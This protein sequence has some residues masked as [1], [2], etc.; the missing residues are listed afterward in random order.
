MHFIND[1]VLC[2]VFGVYLATT[3]KLKHPSRQLKYVCKVTA[4][5][6]VYAT[7]DKWTIANDKK[8]H[9][10]LINIGY[11]LKVVKVYTRVII[12]LFMWDRNKTVL[13]IYYFYIK[14]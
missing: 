14:N 8:T 3:C 9:K 12:I 10:Y 4:E 7:S 5:G 11:K 13:I 6:L 2:I 1:Y